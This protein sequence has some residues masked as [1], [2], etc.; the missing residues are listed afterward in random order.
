MLVENFLKKDKMSQP[1]QKQKVQ[2]GEKNKT[3]ESSKIYLNKTLFEKKKMLDLGILG[4]YRCVPDEGGKNIV[5]H[6]ISNQKTRPVPKSRQSKPK[7]VNIMDGDSILVDDLEV[8]D[9]VNLGD[10]R[11]FY[12]YFVNTDKQ[13]HLSL[14]PIM[15]EEDKSIIPFYV[16]ELWK[17]PV[18]A[19]E[20]I[21]DIDAL[22]MVLPHPFLEDQFGL[23]PK[24]KDQLK[25][26]IFEYSTSTGDLDIMLDDGR[27]AFT[28][29][30]G[31]AEGEDLVSLIKKELKL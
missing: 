4:K 14:S 7:L 16:T 9:L 26:V 18:K 13:G 23:E 31:E 1:L 8:G 2:L 27:N 20:D 28:L 5:L 22:E 11:L 24:H 30:P 10:Y 12:G 21:D 6:L 15:A 29:E 3:K 17:N 25:N 19:Y